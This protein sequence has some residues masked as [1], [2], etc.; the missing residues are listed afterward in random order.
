[1]AQLKFQRLIF[2][3]K[4]SQDLAAT[5]WPQHPEILIRLK[6][7]AAINSFI[8]SSTSQKSWF[9]DFGNPLSASV[10]TLAASERPF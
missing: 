3:L 4:P 2:L 7:G 6:E 1:L 8:L 10:D 5:T 9:I